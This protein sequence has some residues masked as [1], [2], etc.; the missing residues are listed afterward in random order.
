MAVAHRPL[1]GR[2]R[3]DAAA[4]GG[5]LLAQAVGHSIAPT[6]ASVV[7]RS[8]DGGCVTHQALRSVRPHS[9]RPINSSVTT[10]IAASVNVGT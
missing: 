7:D 4:F 9:P 8:R 10:P 6:R 5:K 2:H 3:I 1:A